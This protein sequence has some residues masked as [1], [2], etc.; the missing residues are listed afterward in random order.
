[1]QLAPPETV[2]DP[3]NAEIE[4][5]T[6]P[7][8]LKISGGGTITLTGFKLIGF[9]YPSPNNTPGIIHDGN[10]QIINCQFQ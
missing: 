8:A 9:P 6:Y 7:F 4:V 5:G 10:L 3:N 2:T 1:M